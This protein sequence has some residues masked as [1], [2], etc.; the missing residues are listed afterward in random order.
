MSRRDQSWLSV[1]TA[2]ADSNEYRW[3]HGCVVTKGG[4]ILSVGQSKRRNDPRHVDPQHLHHCSVHAE[5]DALARVSN[6]RNTTVYVARTNKKGE[7][8]NS[9]PCAN[10]E[11]FMRTLGIR[12]VVY[13]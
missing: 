1:A 9:K 2:I 13:T 12:K 10:C 6:P 11:T 5:A 4:K 7:R 3:K 8:R